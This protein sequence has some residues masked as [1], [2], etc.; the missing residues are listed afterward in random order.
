L[1]SRNVGD[2]D[3]HGPPH[4]I[5]LTYNTMAMIEKIESTRQV[6]SIF[7]EISWLGLAG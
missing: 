5:F 1:S 4:S 2:T 6:E 3:E 7:R